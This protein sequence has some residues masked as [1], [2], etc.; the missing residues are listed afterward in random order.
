MI[1]ILNFIESKIEFETKMP[2][3]MSI[4]AHRYLLQFLFVHRLMYCHRK[5]QT[6]Y[7]LE[8]N[9]KPLVSS[10]ELNSNF[11]RSEWLRRMATYFI[12]LFF[13]RNTFDYSLARQIDIWS[14]TISSAYSE[15]EYWPYFA[16][17]QIILP[18]FFKYIFFSGLNYRPLCTLII[19]LFMVTS[20]RS[21]WLITYFHPTHRTA[22]NR[23]CASARA[24]YAII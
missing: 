23:L 4:W 16:A 7:K 21:I 18:F 5:K 17:R 8:I 3:Q 19:S 13:A 15:S 22:F 20:E 1:H 12:S 24:R 6:E 11:V 2:C 14:S 9:C 10:D